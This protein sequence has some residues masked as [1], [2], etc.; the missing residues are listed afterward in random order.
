MC[1]RARRVFVENGR[2]YVLGLLQLMVVDVRDPLAPVVLQ[3]I[4]FLPRRDGGLELRSS[5]GCGRIDRGAD[6]LCDA[7]GAGGAFGRAAAAFD[8]GRLFLSLLGHVYVLD[9]SE[10]PAPIVEAVV[11][12]GWVRDMAVEGPFL[13]ANGVRHESSVIGRQADGS[14]T[15]VGVHDVYDWVDGT[16]TIGDWAVRSSRGRLSVATKQ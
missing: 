1:G 7:I 14:W 4:R 5:S 15:A 12:S 8:H 9:V 13:Y 3:R 10:P 6:R 2:A 11:P 16:T